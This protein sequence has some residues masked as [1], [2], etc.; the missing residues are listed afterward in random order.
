MTEAD[1]PAVIEPAE[2]VAGVAE[3]APKPGL[4]NLSGLSLTLAVIAL[5]L[6]IGLAVAAWF[7]W[8]QVQELSGRQA[9]V[10]AGMDARV[11]PLRTSL[12]GVN[13]A[14]RQQRE[15][16]ASRLDR[17]QQEQQGVA[18]RLSLLSSVMGQTER[19]WTLAEVEY[20]LR[21]ASQR[22]QLQHDTRSAAQALEAA[23]ARL[24]EFADPHY[25][26]VRQQIARDLEAVRGVPPV[27][28]DG[29]AAA[30]GSALQAVDS[31]TV[32]GTRYQPPSDVQD[33][34]EHDAQAGNL[35]ELGQLV[36]S[37]VSGLF[38][39]REH[40][41]AVQP[42][43]PPDSEYFLR[44]NLRL[45]LV[46][47]RLALLRGDRGQYRAALQTALAWLDDYFD[48]ADVGVGQLRERLKALAEIDVDPP[49]PDISDSLRLLRQ[50]MQLAERQAAAKTGSGADAGGGEQAG[51]GG[52]SP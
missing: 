25:R 38:R 51:A 35:E 49:L 34:G 21:I 28:V 41:H 43:L 3:P 44:E 18:R 33:G 36:W 16:M 45:Q 50:Q 8:F 48:A 14:L 20:L 22:L 4:R 19:G 29:I 37:S 40:A 32:T 1:H 17:L 23:D 9:A 30:L 12:D 52:N 11:A 39:L 5:M 13:L 7:T 26:S 10:E 42:M 15:T 31:L 27:D 47:A 46:A 2:P 6:G 24:R